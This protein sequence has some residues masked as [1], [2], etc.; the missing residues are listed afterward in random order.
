MLFFLFRKSYIFWFFLFNKKVYNKSWKS[1][2]TNNLTSENK[3]LSVKNQKNN[4]H[5]S[6]CGWKEIYWEKK[7]QEE[8]F[9]ERRIEECYEY[10]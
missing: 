9:K 8:E 5:L 7:V 1:R 6:I 3:L 4:H 10:F 2:K